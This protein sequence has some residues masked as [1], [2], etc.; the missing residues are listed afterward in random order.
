M[1]EMEKNQRQLIS[2]NLVSILFH[3]IRSKMD[4]GKL[5]LT[6]HSMYI[7]INQILE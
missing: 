6:C 7:C 2:E 3:H 5:I 4:W 1:M